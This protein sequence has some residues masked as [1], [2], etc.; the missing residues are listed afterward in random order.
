MNVAEISPIKR[1][2]KWFWHIKINA[3]DIVITT[4]NK[5]AIISHTNVVQP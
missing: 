1:V 5:A 3:K 2:V 4:E